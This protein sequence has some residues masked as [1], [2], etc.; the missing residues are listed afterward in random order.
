ML[1]ENR[2]R[3]EPEDWGKT[4]WFLLVSPMDGWMCSRQPRK[5]IERECSVPFSPHLNKCPVPLKSKKSIHVHSE[6]LHL[7]IQFHSRT[8]QLYSVPFKKRSLVFKS[9]QLYSV[10]FKKRSLVLTSIQKAFIC[11]Q[12]EA[13][14]IQKS[15]FVFSSI[16]KS[17]I[18][19]S[20]I[21]KEV[22]CIQK[23]VTCI[24]K[25][26]IVFSSIQKVF[27]CIQFHSRV[28]NCSQFHSKSGHLYSLPFKR[29]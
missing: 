29:P 27:I 5:S 15:S 18:V 28:F 8:L 20:S 14:C 25:S 21:Q 12:K 13:T 10:P 19:F 1:L 7:C 3:P 2:W 22:T 24:Q 11:I 16:Q 9:L 23:A 26:S 6:S 17:S 4:W